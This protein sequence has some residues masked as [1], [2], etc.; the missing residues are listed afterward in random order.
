M[1][2][3]SK[4]RKAPKQAAPAAPLEGMH[5]EVLGEVRRFERRLSHAPEKVWRALTDAKE[6]A[7]WFPAIM[8]GARERGASLRFVFPAGE[9]PSTEGNVSEGRITEHEPPRLLEYTMGSETLRWELAAIPEGT[10]LVFTTEVKLTS[11]PA[12][13]NAVEACRMA[14]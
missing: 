11:A 13:D 8:E 12:N 4:K 2:E 6:L 3:S 5:I 14:A 7:A 10:L 9:A 1:K